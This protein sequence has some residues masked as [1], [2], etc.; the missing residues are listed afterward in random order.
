MLNFWTVLPRCI[1]TTTFN[2]R[3]TSLEPGLRSPLTL[4]LLVPWAQPAMPLQG[5]ITHSMCEKRSQW[6]NP[7]PCHVKMAACEDLQ[8]TVTAE[9]QEPHKLPIIWQHP[10]PS[11]RKWHPFSLSLSRW[12]QNTVCLPSVLTPHH[13]VAIPIVVPSLR[14]VCL[15]SL[16][17]TVYCESS[18]C[19]RS[20][21]SGLIR[22]REGDRCGGSSS[23]YQNKALLQTPRQL[24]FHSRSGKMDQG[25]WEGGA[26][27][28]TALVIAQQETYAPHTI[29]MGY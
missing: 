8:S 16:C 13:W 3:V 12:G 20:E 15:C 25:I 18:R 22:S 24:E 4:H 21:A 14:W 26:I 19:G 6:W 17:I 11:L 10:S 2:L 5:V 9:A 27:R 28:G 7:E 1:D 29:I 23:V